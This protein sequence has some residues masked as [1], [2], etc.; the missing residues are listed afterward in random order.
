VSVEETVTG[1]PARPRWRRVLVGGLAAGLLGLLVGDRGLTATPPGIDPLE[2]LDLQVKPNVLFILDSSDSMARTVDSSHRVAGDD[3]QSRFYQ[4]KLA[5]RQLIRDN[6]GRANFGLASMHSAPSKLELNTNGPLV[7]VSADGTATTWAGFFDDPSIDPLVYGDDVLS[8]NVFESLDS[9]STSFDQPYPTGCTPGVDCRYYIKSRRFRNGVKISWD[10][11]SGFGSRRNAMNLPIQPF[12]CP[13]PPAGLLGDDVDEANDGAESRPCF[14]IEELSGLVP[15]GRIS[16]FYY[17][18]GAFGTANGGPSPGPNVCDQ[19][20]V[21]V[22]VQQCAAASNAA[23]ILDQVKLSLPIDAATGN[24]VGFP[25]DPPAFDLLDDANS[26]PNVA[27]AGLRIGAGSPIQGALVAA[28]QHYQTVVYPARPAAVVGLQK[29]FVI[30]ITDSDPESGCQAAGQAR[31][32]AQ[33]MYN[34]GGGDRIE[35]LVVSYAAGAAVTASLNALAAA[36]SDPLVPR[37]VFSA[38]TPEELKG[39]LAFAFADTIAAGTFSTESSITESIYEYVSAVPTPASPVPTPSPFSADDPTTRYGARIPVLLQTSFDMPGFRGHL[40]AFINAD[41]TVN[42]V[43]KNALTPKWDAG[44][45]LLRRVVDGVTVGTGMGVGQYDFDTVRGPSPTAP[46]F[47]PGGSR[48]QR[49]IFTSGR[50][51]VFPYGADGSASLS[52]QPV[53]LWPPNDAVAPRDDTTAGS[54]DAALGIDALTFAELRSQFGACAGLAGSLPAACTAAEPLRTQRAR[55]EAREMIL[56]YTAGAD[57]V[58]TTAGLPQRGPGAAFNVLYRA[59]SWILP[60][61]TLAV[62]AVITP[63]LESRPQIHTAEYQLFRDGARTLAG[64]ATS[65]CP[66]GAGTCVD[67]GF[68]LRNP[69]KDGTPASKAAADLKPVMSVVYHAANDMLHAFRAGPRV[70]TAAGA[71]PAA[72]TEESG[73]EELWGFVPFDQLDKLKERM[74]AQDRAGHAYVIA[75]SVRFVDVFV[76]D[77]N[78]YTVEG[79]TYTGRWRVVVVFGRGIGGKHYTALDVTAPGPFNRTALATNPP[80]L[81]WNRGNPDTQDGLAPSGT[82]ENFRTNNQ[83]VPVPVISQDLGATDLTAYSKMGETW[84]IPAIARAPLEANF[85]VEYA[86]FTGSGYSVNPLEGKTFYVMNALTG[87]VLHAYDVPDSVGACG[88]PPCTAPPNAIVAGPAAYIAD[89]LVTGF[90]G[91]PAASKASLVYVGDLHGRLWKFITS[92]PSRGLLKFKD[93]GV[94]QPIA[95]PVALLNLKGPHVYVETGNDN[96]VSPPPNFRLWAFRDD[97]ADTNATTNPDPDFGPC[98][99]LSMP[100][101]EKLFRLDLGAPDTPL[102]GFR[103]TAQPA[104]AFNS[105]DPAT[106]RGRVFY[107]ATKFIPGAADCIPNFNSA[108]FGLGAVTGDAAYDLNAAGDDR[109]VLM[110][111]QKINAVR[112]ASGQIVLDKGV[113]GAAPPAPPPP[114]APYAGPVGG[115]GDVFVLRIRANSSVCNN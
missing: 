107:I 18:A 93:L 27:G 14:A 94:D 97:A 8:A 23:T 63:P 85:N 66:L 38:N 44:E 100:G 115:S 77:E 48:I 39:A 17:T 11:T 41:L 24:P 20:G 105:S 22:P 103:G 45:K 31:A 53:P 50:N 88:S 40:K 109:Y 60:E 35:T 59:R 83:V 12:A 49:R 96:R 21:V 78:G 37:T 33:A 112:G 26:Q 42:G 19:S 6:D 102:D 47:S 51:G 64:V 84:S 87:D 65:S 73:G 43:L 28:Q 91:N 72:A 13:P 110:T 1:M 81:L 76:P 46:L 2:I 113:L 7:Y 99:G 69:D 92:S 3:P 98:G 10:A 5:V 58:Q 9:N 108:F 74:K 79:R 25:T 55:R 67:Q 16:I 104:T 62:P 114:P 106:A 90:V 82:N 32:Q 36:G 86:A 57:V 80:I 68:G 34:L 111:G 4:T 52:Q 89:Q 61:S 29:N 70:C 56:A 54:L 30:L 75:S 95:N 71:C 15:T 101:C